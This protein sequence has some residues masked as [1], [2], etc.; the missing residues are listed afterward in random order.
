M[1]AAGRC[2]AA[3]GRTHP[4]ALC[5][6][7]V[8]KKRP[9]GPKGAPRAAR[10]R[11]GRPQRRG[12]STAGRKAGGERPA[13]CGRPPAALRSRRHRK[14]APG[15]LVCP[16]KT[17]RRGWIGCSA[18]RGGAGPPERAA[19]RACL[20]CLPRWRTHLV[21]RAAAAARAARDHDLRNGPCPRGLDT[22]PWGGGRRRGARRAARVPQ[23]EERAAGCS[24]RR[25]SAAA[26]ARYRAPRATARAPCAPPKVE[27][28]PRRRN[29]P[30]RGARAPPARPK[31]IR[32]L[33]S[34]GRSLDHPKAAW[35]K[36]RARRAWSDSG[37]AKRGGSASETKS[38]PPGGWVAR[39]TRQRE[40]R[41]KGHQGCATYAGAPLRGANRAPAAPVER[42]APLDR[43]AG[44][45]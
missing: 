27:R 19:P 34:E 29:T 21:P 12:G 32:R 11:R 36:A 18:A 23:P 37:G 25:A 28:A 44:G 20:F 7:G 10:V 15:A 26:P 6:G 43:A 2:S 39:E 41:A 17:R 5:V 13:R 45:P 3:G 30:P 42:R 24:G 35:V 40:T 33:S 14:R 22:E 38:A 9:A 31:V 1:S 16:N 4:R 8:L